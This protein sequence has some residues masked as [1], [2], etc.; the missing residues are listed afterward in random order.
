VQIGHQSTAW[1]NLAD[2]ALRAG[3]HYSHEKAIAVR[4]N[5]EPWGSLVDQIEQ[6]LKH[7]KVDINKS[8][9]QLGPMLE[10]DAST[11]KFVG[12]G[13]VNANRYLQREYRSN[14]EVP[15]IA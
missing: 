14:Y 12:D 7:N 3:K 15:A 13:S 1:C 9:F 6:H 4:E 8:T 5:F 10:F 11:Q 2:V